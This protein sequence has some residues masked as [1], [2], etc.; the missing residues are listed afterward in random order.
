MARKSSLKTLD[1]NALERYMKKDPAA[2]DEPEKDK[3][4]AVEPDNSE[5]APEAAGT[6]TKYSR[7]KNPNSLRNLHPREKGT[8]KNTNS[9]G[10][11]PV[12]IAEYYDYIKTM[13]KDAKMSRNEYIRNLIRKDMEE[14]KERYELLKKLEETK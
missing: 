9:R 8:G 2:A 4:A 1:T 12:Y 7:G 3:T 5:T 13:A 6:E 14:R 10:Y 11:M